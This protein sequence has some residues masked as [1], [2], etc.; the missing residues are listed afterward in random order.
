MRFSVEPES[1]M[2]I[3]FSLNGLAGVNNCTL[4]NLF[5]CG[6]A[7]TEYGVRCSLAVDVLHSDEGRDGVVVSYGWRN[8]SGQVALEEIDDHIAFQW[9]VFFSV[10]VA[11]L[12][13]DNTPTG[14]LLLSP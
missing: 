12:M 5:V 14:A 2:D 9:A 11:L 13:V 1:W 8:G 6:R 4:G 3:S 10:S 7:T